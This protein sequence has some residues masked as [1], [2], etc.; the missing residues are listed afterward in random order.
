MFELISFSNS[1]LMVLL[2]L[3]QFTQ[4][5]EYMKRRASGV[6]ARYNL[7]SGKPKLLASSMFRLGIKTRNLKKLVHSRSGKKLGWDLRQSSSTGRRMNL[8]PQTHLFSFEENCLFLVRPPLMRNYSCA[9]LIGIRYIKGVRTAH[10]GG[11]FRLMST[12]KMM[13]GIIF[14]FHI[15]C[16]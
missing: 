9:S 8:M 15:L 3:W 10:L 5:A 7:Q 1:F 2:V 16:C 13:A 14:F 4:S 11:C 12:S 6:H